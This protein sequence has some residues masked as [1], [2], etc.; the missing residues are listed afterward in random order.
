[1][2]KK[3]SREEFEKRMQ[4]FE[5]DKELFRNKLINFTT[6]LIDNENIK[7]TPE[8]V[9]AIAEASKVCLQQFNPS[10]DF[11]MTP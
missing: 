7:K 3:L 2:D 10:I 1:M 9:L 6:E 5:K 11:K 8:M 4:E